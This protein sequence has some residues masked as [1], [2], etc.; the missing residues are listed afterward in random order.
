MAKQ[1]KIKRFSLIISV[2][3]LGLSLITVVFPKVVHA[4]TINLQ[5]IHIVKVWKTQHLTQAEPV[6]T[7]KDSVASI[8]GTVTTQTAD[9]ATYCDDQLMQVTDSKIAKNQTSLVVDQVAKQNG[10]AV[11]YHIATSSNKAPDTWVSAHEVTYSDNL[12]N[13]QN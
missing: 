13:I 12:L 4:S 3:V 7:T 8:N 2:I 6:D 9:L 5:G 11:A 10:Q 1:A